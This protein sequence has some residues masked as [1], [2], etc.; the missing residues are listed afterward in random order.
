M[1]GVLLRA[2]GN[3]NTIELSGCKADGSVEFRAI[4]GQNVA[5]PVVT[6]IEA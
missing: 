1:E 5:T 2:L 6:V 3:F 4:H